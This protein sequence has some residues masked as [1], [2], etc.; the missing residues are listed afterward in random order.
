MKRKSIHKSVSLSLIKQIALSIHPDELTID[1][2]A[3]AVLSQSSARKILAAELA[4][5]ENTIEEYIFENKIL[6]SSSD[7]DKYDWPQEL[8]DELEFDFSG[9]LDDDNS[10]DKFEKVEKITNLQDL[11]KNLI[12]VTK[13]NYWYKRTLAKNISELRDKINRCYKK[14][15]ELMPHEK[16]NIR[17]LLKIIEKQEVQKLIIPTN[18]QPLPIC[19]LST[20][21]SNEFE[22]LELL[23]K[24]LTGKETVTFDQS[25]PVFDEFESALKDE[26][27]SMVTFRLSLK[28]SDNAALLKL[29]TFLEIG[30]DNHFSDLMVNHFNVGKIHIL[31]LHIIVLHI[32]VPSEFVLEPRE[33]ID[34]LNAITQF[35]EDVIS[36]SFHYET[37]HNLAIRTL[38]IGKSEN[39]FIKQNHDY[40][41][42]LL[43]LKKL[44]SCLVDHL[45]SIAGENANIL[46]TEKEIDQLSHLVFLKF[47]SRPFNNMVREAKILFSIIYSIRESYSKS[48]IE[49]VDNNILSLSR[50]DFQDID[51]NLTIEHFI[52]LQKNKQYL[53]FDYEFDE[54]NCTIRFQN[55]NTKYQFDLRGNE[56]YLVS[57]TDLT[58]DDVIGLEEVKQRLLTIL[59]YLKNPQPFEK[60]RV[61]PPLR[62]LLY[63]PPGTGK[64]MIAKAFANKVEFPFYSISAS[65]FTSQKYAGFGATLL[66]NIFS[67]AVKNA[68]S[69][70]FLDELDAFGSRSNF[71]EDSVGFDAKSIMNSLLVLLDGINSNEKVIVLAATNRIEDLDPALLRPKRF[72]TKI[73]IEPVNYNQRRNF[74]TQLLHKNECTEDYE[75]IIKSILSRTSSDISPAVLED[76]INEIK[77]K[78]ISDHHEKVNLQEVNDVI[79]DYLLGKKINVLNAE[80]KMSKAYNSAGFVVLH[81]LFFPNEIIE[82][83]SIQYRAKSFGEVVLNKSQQNDERILSDDELLGLMVVHFG[84][85]LSERKKCGKFDSASSIDFLI[86][87]QISMMIAGNFDIRNGMRNNISYA[88]QKLG[89]DNYE[90]KKELTVI[91]ENIIKSAER[92]S[93]GLIE[94]FWEHICNIAEALL[95]DEILDRE[96]INSLTISL[97]EED[98]NVHK[99]I[100]TFSLESRNIGFQMIKSTT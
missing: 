49:L 44:R 58:F 15:I 3:K 86:L 9:L 68:P 37:E 26:S 59:A 53:D 22:L 36:D 93:Q 95:R 18:Q 81:R 13:R 69:V 8:F 80:L 55:F 38:N 21:Y 96:M 71:N 50:N 2:L 39:L 35:L 67:N 52:R 4:V 43:M 99:V 46:F 66:R 64:T 77:L 29:L 78:A 79:D 27:L 83:I 28:P 97:V 63:G 75:G 72:G 40:D 84:G 76:I 33:D 70:I 14:A 85:I 54:P 57:K 65:E 23:S 42:A 5:N 19:I 89:I 32:Q 98:F 41:E 45:E 47:V 82:K 94:K 100:S 1:S 91:A 90:S 92:I 31:G 12:S 16:R 62:L 74:L 61:R 6:I 30:Y 88:F 56:K 25:H 20:N 60:L 7:A 24:L 34:Q 17:K 10:E 73:K 87:G 11:V 51:Q 48:K